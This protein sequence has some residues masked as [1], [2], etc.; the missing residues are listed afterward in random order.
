MNIILSIVYVYHKISV[1][2]IRAITINLYICAITFNL[3]STLSYIVASQAY[4]N[5]D[6]ISSSTN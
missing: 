6:N 2:A 1:A 5:C 4:I 3:I